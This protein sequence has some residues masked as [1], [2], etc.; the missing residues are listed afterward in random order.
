M[1]E[2]ASRI[3]DFVELLRIDQALGDLYY[4][5]V[6]LVCDR[7]EVVEFGRHRGLKIPRR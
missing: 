3:W 6:L 1:I 7:A 2:E 5:L 4:K